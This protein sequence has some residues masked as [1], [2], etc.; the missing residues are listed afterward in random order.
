[1]SDAYF[2]AAGHDSYAP[3]E[4][5]GGAWNDVD[6]HFAPLAG[7]VTHHLDRWRSAHSD[8]AKRVSRITFEILGRLP[9]GDV[10]LTT[11]VVRPGRTIELLET[12]AAID[13]RAV[14]TAR[15]WALSDGDTQRVEGGAWHPLPSPEDCPSFE[16]HEAWPGG[17]LPTL[18][19]RK[20]GEPAPGRATAW[21]RTDLPLVAD[22]E[23]SALASYILLLDTSNSIAMREAPEEWLFP[24]VE[25]T[26]HLFRAPVG[27]WSG[28]DTTVSFGPTGQGLTSSVLHDT[29]GPL[30]TAQQLL[31][32]RPV[33]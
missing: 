21:V 3:T 18:D 5:T 16:L 17:F 30:G 20:V 9:R 28:L 13:G 33:A 7:I 10:E 22:E 32:V 2:V 14:V 19:V 23:S 4:H 29:A 6:Q 1:M 11:R 25:L 15:A 12:T 27:P 8:P 26:A 31:T 24:N